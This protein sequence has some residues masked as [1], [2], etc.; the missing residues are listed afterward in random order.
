[1]KGVEVVNGDYSGAL[2]EAITR[3]NESTAG[4]GELV[5][6]GVEKVSPLEKDQEATENIDKNVNQ[7]KSNN[8]TTITTSYERKEK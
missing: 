8:Q 7:T 6:V 4:D 1:M 2:R 5:V 3:R